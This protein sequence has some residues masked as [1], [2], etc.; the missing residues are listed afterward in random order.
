MSI[1]KFIEATEKKKLLPEFSILD[2]IQMFDVAWGKVRTKSIVNCIGKAVISKEKQSKALLDVDDPFKDL[3]EQLNKLVVY[4][5]K[6][7]LEG[8][9]ANDIVSVDDS[10][11][12]TEPLMTDDAI[13]CDVLDE[14]GSE[15][16]DDTD[17][18]SN[19]PICPQ[20]SDVRQ[21][22]DVP[23][24]CMLFNDNREF[25]NK[26]LNEISVLVENELSAKLSQADIRSFSSRNREN[27]GFTG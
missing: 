6:F 5:A 2:V 24:E 27:R 16:E 3:Q 17:D 11:T 19:E 26:F 22:V 1:K 14:E 8:T 25:I 21:A 9:T 23:R 10:L 4:N 13:L 20:S 18:V 12:S 7:F 15:T